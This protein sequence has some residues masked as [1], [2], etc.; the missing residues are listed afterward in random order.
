ML[1]LQTSFEL[2][3]EIGTK[4]QDQSFVIG[5]HNVNS[6]AVFV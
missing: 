4:F 5:H 1:N 2:R 3:H 6:G